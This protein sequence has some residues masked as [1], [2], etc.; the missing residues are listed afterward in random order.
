MSQ[1]IPLDVDSFE[2]GYTLGKYVSAILNNFP[3]SVNTS[4]LIEMLN[5]EILMP[6]ELGSVEAIIYERMEAFNEVF[7]SFY[8]WLGSHPEI[9]DSIK[10][11]MRLVKYHYDNFIRDFHLAYQGAPVLRANLDRIGS[12]RPALDVLIPDKKP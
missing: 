6:D 1:R 7:A 9:T 3:Q 12:N 11:D 4:P 8:I 5:D 2:K 10:E